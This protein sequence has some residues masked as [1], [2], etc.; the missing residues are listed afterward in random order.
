[1]ISK[2]LL[3][4]SWFVR[5]LLY[6]LPDIPLCM[7]FRGFLYSF[8][9]QKCGRDFQITHN[10]I[11]KGLQ[12]ISVGSNVFVGNFSVIMGSGKL[13]IEN[14]V[15]IGPH[16]VIISGNHTKSKNSYRYGQAKVGDIFIGRGSWITSNCT[17]GMNSSLPEG[18]VLSANS[19]LN[20][21]FETPNAI[22]GGV[23]AK[24]IKNN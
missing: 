9:M 23:P 21:K 7:R 11:I 17:I 16:V 14:E 4:Y 18:S 1:M 5:A 12:N 3:I 20:K 6:F 2:L 24:F 8:G 22:Y 15:L 10:A 13:R 19:F